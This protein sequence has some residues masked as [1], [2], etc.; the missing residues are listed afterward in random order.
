MIK[1]KKTVQ[2]HLYVT[3]IFSIHFLHILII[4]AILSN[5]AILSLSIKNDMKV[6]IQIHEIVE[7]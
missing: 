2:S 6:L 7:Y 4:D 5:Y 3:I 1:M